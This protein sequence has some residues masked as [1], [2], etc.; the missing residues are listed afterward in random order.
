VTHRGHPEADD[1]SV[2][3]DTDEDEGDDESGVTAHLKTLEQLHKAG[4]IDAEE[5]R[6]YRATLLNYPGVESDD[7]GVESDDDDDDYAALQ[8]RR[9]MPAPM[10]ATQRERPAGVPPQQRPPA[11]G[12]AA[13]SRRADARA[14]L[15]WS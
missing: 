7:E 12:P 5:L 9:P 4:H 2:D 3:T 10:P 14:D 1:H 13:S 11:R 6:Q 15:S 8:R